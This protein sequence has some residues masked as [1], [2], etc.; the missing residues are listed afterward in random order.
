MRRACS[1]YRWQW[2]AWFTLSEPERD[3]LL[4]QERQ[5]DDLI[6]RYEEKLKADSK[7]GTI[8]AEIGIPLVWMR[9][10]YA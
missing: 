10:G 7:E 9:L 4:E 3:Y 5:L 8:S 1:R 2:A 6:T